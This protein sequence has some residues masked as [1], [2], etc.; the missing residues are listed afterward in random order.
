MAIV[1]MGGFG[2]GPA[3]LLLPSDGPELS[4]SERERFRLAEGLLSWG[5]FRGKSRDEIQAIMGVPEQTDYFSDWDEVYVLGP[6]RGWLSI[7]HE[8]LVVNYDDQGKAIEAAIL[9]D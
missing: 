7:D 8:W 2:I 4:E 6:E 3:V 5:T 1:L 9:S